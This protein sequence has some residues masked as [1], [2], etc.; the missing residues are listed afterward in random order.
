MRVRVLGCGA[1]GG[2]PRIG[3]DWGACD[4]TEP[5]NRRRRVSIL[6]ESGDTTILVDT[7][8]DLREQLLDAGTRKIDAII[9]THSHA[10]HLH[11]L[12]DLRALNRLMHR[13]I[14]LYADPATM[15]EIA[16]RFDY[17]I[18]PPDT[19]NSF[20]KPMVVPQEMTGAFAINGIPVVPYDQD[21]G[22]SRSSGLRI[23]DLGY[24]TDVVEMSEEGFQILAGIDVWIVDC[25]RYEPH[26]TH[27]HLAKTLGWIE[28]VKPR[29]SVLTHMDVQLDYATLRREVP[30]GVEPGYDGLTVEVEA[31]AR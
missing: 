18:Q 2:V 14:P 29:R 17:V 25:L 3:G 21:H 13:P 9:I 30:E 28:R 7:S 5:R 27:S 8:P 6:I 1:S 22:F 15:R 31:S 12:D 23:G 24:S 19:P 20:Y 26:P 10:D 16:R 11:G 4:P